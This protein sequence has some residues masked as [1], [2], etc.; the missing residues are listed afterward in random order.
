MPILGKG[1][2][3][4]VVKANTDED[5]K[6][7]KIRRVDAS[8]KEL[9]HEANMLKLANSVDV[10]PKFHSVSK[11]CLLM[12]LIDGNLLPFW[13]E[14]FNKK[15]VV[16][17]VFRNLLEQCKQLDKI[18]LDHGELSKA[19]KHIIINKKMKPYIVDYE[20]ASNTRIVSNVT[21]ICQF[22][23]LSHGPVAIAASKIFGDLDGRK[24]IQALK[25][26]KTKKTKEN[27][28]LVLQACS[29][30]YIANL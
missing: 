21:S 2:V 23:F 1:F 15:R 7:A 8:R 28:K 9:Q 11:N 29:L 27:F 25:K 22:L 10:G 26:Y 20:T 6:A 24:I 12:E 18:G 16:K 19:P 14:S 4:I 13:L 30:N 5:S 3:G 17:N